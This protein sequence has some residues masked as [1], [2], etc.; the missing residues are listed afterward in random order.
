MKFEFCFDTPKSRS[1]PTSKLH[2]VFGL[3]V[4]LFLGEALSEEDR[5]H[6]S[7]FISILVLTVRFGIVYVSSSFCHDVWEG[8]G[9]IISH[10]VEVSW[11]DG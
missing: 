5:I 4:H 10:T 11:P 9:S 7:L 2:N 6:P 8:Q 1:K 3:S